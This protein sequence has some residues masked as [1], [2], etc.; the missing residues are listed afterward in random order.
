MKNLTTKIS[1]ATLGIL[2]IV[3]MFSV[4]T[5]R[6]AEGDEPVS[7]GKGLC[8]IDSKNVYA[9]KDKGLEQVIEEYHKNMNDKFNEYT[10]KMLE[11]QEKASKTN[12]PDPNSKAPE[13]GDCTGLSDNYST[14]C[15]AKTLLSNETSGY[16]E[17]LKALDCRKNQFFDTKEDELSYADVGETILSAGVSNPG[18]VEEQYPEIYQ[19]QKSMEMSARLDAVTRE[20]D[21]AK[22][23]LDV[24]LA[25]Y[26]ELKTA[27]AMHK[28]YVEIYESLVK[29]RDK[30]VEIRHQVEDFPS[31]FIDATTTMCT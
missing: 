4:I 25:T 19:L 13:S 2:L 3:M 7:D 30:M 14:Y 12:T 26:N 9:A 28:R 1:L 20:I 6:A 8:G 15:V 31:K 11:E 5:S 18:A 10:K 29:Y 16:M 17:Y 21:S 23:T 24:T 22:Q 27:W